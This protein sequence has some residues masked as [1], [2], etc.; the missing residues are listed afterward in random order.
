[1]PTARERIVNN[2]V[3]LTLFAL[4]LATVLGGILLAWRVGGRRRWAGVA[5]AGLGVAL[6]GLLVLMSSRFWFGDQVFFHSFINIELVDLVV[7]TL[8]TLIPIA[9]SAGLAL[10]AGRWVAARLGER[11]WW[12]RVLAVCG[13]LLAID[14][15]GTAALVQLSVVPEAEPVSPID[16]TITVA[17]G[18]HAELIVSQGIKS[19]TALT[20]G[21]DGNLYVSDM[22]GRIWRIA[23]AQDSAGAPELFA[24]NFEQPLG[25]AWRGDELYVASLGLISVISDQDGDGLAEQRRVIVRDLPV[26]LFPLHQ[27]NAIKFGPDG[28]LY[29]GLGAGNNSAEETHELT[30]TIL[31][32]NPDGSDIQVYAR[33]LRNAYGLAFNAAGDLFATDNA[34]QGMPI[35]P[36]DE[37]NHIRAGN[38]YGYPNDYEQPMPGHTTVGPLYVFPPHS[39]PDGITFYDQSEFP[40]EYRDNAFVASWMRGEIYRVQL[41]KAASGDYLARVTM[42]ASGFVNPLDLTAGPDGSLYIGDFGTSA[43][44]RVEYRPDEQRPA[45]EAAKP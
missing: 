28:R 10:L 29:F 27:N 19:P 17:P 11:R 3:A 26:R 9:L 31:S 41:D 45:P 37:L 35:I 44:Y 39:S 4:F 40:Q 43:I 22:S 20:F 14:A 18:F 24:D 36:G 12:P 23:T 13:A 34:P 33:G 1:M 5:L 25:L 15:L 21:P 16:R 30:A 38:N 7:T 2:V 6:A 32:V 42:F 8:M